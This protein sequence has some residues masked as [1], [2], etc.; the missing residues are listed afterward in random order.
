LKNRP[1]I[2]TDIQGKNRVK[3]WELGTFIAPTIVLFLIFIIYPIIHLLYGSFFNWSGVGAMKFIGLTNYRTLFG[4]WIFQTALKN[5]LI[6]AIFTIFPQMLL[7]FIL[8]ICLDKP[9][10]GRNIYRVIIYMP[11]ILSPVVIG[12]V[13]QNIYDPYMG[14]LGEFLRK[15]GLSSW[16]HAWLAEPQLVIWAIIFINIWQWTGWSMLM[17]LAFLQTIPE[18]LYEAADV[19]GASESQKIAK[20][21]WPMCKTVHLNLILLGVIGTLQTFALVYVLTKGGPNH[22]SEML[23]THIFTQAFTLQNMGY[24]C[25]ISIILVLVGILVSVLQLRNTDD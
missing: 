19:E 5:E 21:I 18:E 22:A 6:W 11:A 3:Y 23:T 8:A 2:V 1:T 16:V 25:T 13:W 14:I 12:I 10:W 17:Y 7:G 15:I 9:I 4:D 24:A 20:I